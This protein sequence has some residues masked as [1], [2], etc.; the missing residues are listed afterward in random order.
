MKFGV[1]QPV[2]RHEEV[3][4][5]S[6][7]YA[8]RSLN[9]P[10]IIDGTAEELSSSSRNA[11]TLCFDGFLKGLEAFCDLCAKAC[12]TPGSGAG[13]ERKRSLPLGI[14]TSAAPRKN[15]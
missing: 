6:C 12:E 14:R 13:N 15:A 9:T 8:A 1:G 2:R 10:I 11:G 4:E 3:R 7:A 5:K